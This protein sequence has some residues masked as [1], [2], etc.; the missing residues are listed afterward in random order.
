MKLHFPALK[1]RIKLIKISL[2]FVSFQILCIESEWPRSF[3]RTAQ[4][5]KAR[6]EVTSYFY[7]DFMFLLQLTFRASN[8][9]YPKVLEDF[10]IMEK[11]PMINRR[12][13][14]TQLS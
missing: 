6:V 1:F 9:D 14:G 10:T 3:E 7:E 11:A 5:T 2:N 13:I 8:E 12:E 4:L